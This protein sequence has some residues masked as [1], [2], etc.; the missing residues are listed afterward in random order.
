MQT[1]HCKPRNFHVLQADRN[2]AAFQHLFHVSVQALIRKRPIVSRKG[3]GAVH[4]SDV[5]LCEGYR[6][7]V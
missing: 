2:D 6:R 7:N 4:G 5:A 1:K 3:N